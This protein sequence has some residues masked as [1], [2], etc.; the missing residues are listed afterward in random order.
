VS[1]DKECFFIDEDN[2]R[3]IP[4]DSEVS[5]TVVVGNMEHKQR[6][7]QNSQST[8]TNETYI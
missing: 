8:V 3:Y 5:Q 7:S 2:S 6:W 1:P 4:P